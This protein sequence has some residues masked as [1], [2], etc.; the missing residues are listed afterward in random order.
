M[1][2]QAELFF[3]W[4][5][6]K[7]KRLNLGYWFASHLSN[8]LSYNHPLILGSYI[9]NLA[10]NMNVLDPSFVSVTSSMLMFPL[11]L[12]SLETMHLLTHHP[13]KT[14]SLCHAGSQKKT[15]NAAYSLLLPQFQGNSLTICK[16]E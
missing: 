11:D 13:D 15:G 4:S 10:F 9:T 6:V 14:V 5:M 3:L 12:S 1:V 2:T 7:G 16:Q 8:S